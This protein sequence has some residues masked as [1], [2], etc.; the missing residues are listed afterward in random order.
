MVQAWPSWGTR[1]VR[2][3][4]L[5][6]ARAARPGAEPA[7]QGREGRGQGTSWGPSTH[8]QIAPCLS[9]PPGVQARAAHARNWG[10]ARQTLDLSGEGVLHYRFRVH[11][12]V[13]ADR[14]WEGWGLGLGG[15]GAV[16]AEAAW[17]SD[18][19]QS[20][21]GK[22][23]PDTAGGQKVHHPGLSFPVCIPVWGMSPVSPLF[24]G[25]CWSSQTGGLLGLAWSQPLAQM[26]GDMARVTQR[27]GIDRLEL[28]E[29]VPSSFDRRTGNALTL[30]S[31]LD[32]VHLAH[33]RVNRDMSLSPGKPNSLLYSSFLCK[34]LLHVLSCEDNFVDEKRKTQGLVRQTWSTH[35]LGKVCACLLSL[36]QGELHGV[37]LQ[38]DWLTS[39]RRVSG[40]VPCV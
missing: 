6:S 30:S 32:P 19:A 18:V 9:L 25:V 4:A 14:G 21:R 3:A 5:V 27:R 34:F 15:G 1:R 29:L 24:P 11:A 16:T 13:L 12:P 36:F 7:R 17:E 26:E 31:T 38:A 35:S 2:P 23:H 37:L 39:G 8:H 33:L 10:C 40:D 22:G 28:E 20:G